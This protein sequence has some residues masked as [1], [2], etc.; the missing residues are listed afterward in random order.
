MK[1]TL[2]GILQIIRPLNCIITFVSII[3]G[4]TISSE[5]EAITYNFILAAFAGLLV[6]AAGNT[7]NDIVDIEIDKTNKPERP[8]PSFKISINQ[9]WILFAFLITASLIISL[10]I[11]YFAFLIVLLSNSLLV[12]YSVSIK[13]VAIFGNIIISFLTG[14]ALIFGAMISGNVKYAIIPAIF[15]FLINFVREIVKDIEDIKGDK[16]SGFNTLP[17][18]FG[19]NA[20]KKVVLIISGLLF[21]FTLVPF[22]FKIY[23]IEFF[24]IVMVVVNPVLFYSVKKLFDDSTLKNLKK[25][26][27]LLKL[28]MILG[29]I[30]IYLGK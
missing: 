19:L 22:V 21:L 2:I 13:R 1:K 17:I 6:A 29:L 28:N 7:I 12:L 20:A 10:L 14:Y 15:A 9:A 30:A 5:K 24:L 27:S 3:I 26:S 11:S 4:A 23:R 18:K 8:L 25:I 16:L